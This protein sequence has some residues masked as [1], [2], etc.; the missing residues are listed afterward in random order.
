MYTKYNNVIK[1]YK[2]LYSGINT[3]KK[4]CKTNFNKKKLPKSR[5]FQNKCLPLHHKTK[6][7]DF[8]KNIINI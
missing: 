8:Y 1:A 4:W 5:Y 6:Q 3:T 2:L 7:E